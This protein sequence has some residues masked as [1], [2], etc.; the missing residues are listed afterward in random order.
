M[1][2]GTVGSLAHSFRPFWLKVFT[3]ITSL[4]DMD[5]RLLLTLRAIRE[6]TWQYS[7]PSPA[8]GTLLTSMASDLKLNP[9]WGDPSHL[10]AHGGAEAD[11]IWGALGLKGRRGV[12]GVPCDIV[13]CGVAG[14]SCTR[15]TL[16]RGMRAFVQA[17]LIY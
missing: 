6:R 5:P 2:N 10:P 15:N 8:H 7:R 4:A 16:L 11:R 9:L 14:N 13:H 1:L 3:R 12:G 17:L